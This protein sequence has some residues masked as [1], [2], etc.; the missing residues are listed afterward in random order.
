MNT[1]ARPATAESGSLV[2]ATSGST[3]ASYWI[4]PSS[5][6]SGARSATSAVA[7]RTFSTSAPDPEVP[8]E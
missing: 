5:A 2:R 8:V 1:V 7:A 6:R 4:G 3:A